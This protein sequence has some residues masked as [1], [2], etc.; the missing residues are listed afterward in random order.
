LQWILCQLL[1]W[2]VRLEAIVPRRTIAE[3]LAETVCGSGYTTSAEF[4]ATLTDHRWFMRSANGHRTHHLHI[5]V[6]GGGFWTDH[7]RFRDLLR[8]DADLA[9]RYAALK[10]RLA[11]RFATDRDAYT[12]AKG[13]FVH[14]AL[15][16]GRVPSPPMD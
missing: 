12:L 1:R 3:A 9:A 8:S 4:S 15:E 6:H 10:V 5:A 16:H 14:S 2:E 13:P 7:I 11:E